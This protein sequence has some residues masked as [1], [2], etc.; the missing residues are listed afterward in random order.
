MKVGDT[1]QINWI[2]ILFFYFVIAIIFFILAFIAMI[3]LLIFLLLIAV[4]SEHIRDLQNIHLFLIVIVLFYISWNGLAYYYLLSGFELLLEAKMISP[5]PSHGTPD[6]RLYDIA[7]F[8]MI[9][10]FVNFILLIFAYCY[11]K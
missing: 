4:Q 11:L 2:W 5:S 6:T 3:L 10:A 7:W 8:M 1:G 9:C